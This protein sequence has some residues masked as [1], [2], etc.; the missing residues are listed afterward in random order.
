[1][2][3]GTVPAG[4]AAATPLALEPKRGEHQVAGARVF[5]AQLTAFAGC[6]VELLNAG[7]HGVVRA[8]IASFVHTLLAARLVDVLILSCPQ[9]LLI[10][11]I[12]PLDL[13]ASPVGFTQKLKA[14]PDAGLEHETMDPNLGCHTRPSSA[15]HE[16]FEHGF[17]GDAMGWIVGLFLAHGASRLVQAAPV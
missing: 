12:E 6:A 3:V 14:R 13:P 10:A 16:I 15:L 1:M 5:I 2:L 8:A 11:Q 17:Q 9:R 7:G 4:A